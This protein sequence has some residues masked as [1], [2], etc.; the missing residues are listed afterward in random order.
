MAFNSPGSQVCKKKE[1][2]LEQNPHY[3]LLSGANES[4]HLKYRSNI[5]TFLFGYRWHINWDTGIDAFWCHRCT[6]NHHYCI[7]PALLHYFFSFL[8]FLHSFCTLFKPREEEN[9]I[10]KVIERMQECK[11]PKNIVEMWGK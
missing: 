5:Q 6:K 3:L 11:T 1:N 4:V 9:N 8:C 2:N 10:I 7:V